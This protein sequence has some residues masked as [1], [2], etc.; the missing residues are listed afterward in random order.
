MNQNV[1]K[2]MKKVND[3]AKDYPKK[4]ENNK[5]KI[6]PKKSIAEDIEKLKNRRE[7]RKKFDEEKKIRNEMKIQN[8]QN[9]GK[10]C[11][12]DF[13]VLIKKKKSSLQ[14]V[15]ENVKLKIN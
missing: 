11:D 3:E 5:N 8:E 1:N 7:E 14:H 6:K 15:S 13:E 4:D 12:V 2:A 9:G 10:A